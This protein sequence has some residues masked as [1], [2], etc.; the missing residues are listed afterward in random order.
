MKTFSKGS[1]TRFPQRIAPGG[2][3]FYQI[4]PSRFPSLLLHVHSVK[5]PEDSRPRPAVH[6]SPSTGIK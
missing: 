1:V 4:S 2:G 5:H 3:A 6:T